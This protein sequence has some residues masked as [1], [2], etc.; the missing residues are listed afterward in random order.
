[1]TDT[2][3]PSV[4]KLSAE[5]IARKLTKSEAI[6]LRVTPEEKELIKSAASKVG[7]T[8]TDYLVRIGTA[9]AGLLNEKTKE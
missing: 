1:M 9:T 5:D 2:P 7:L 6:N 4:P 3:T 8:V